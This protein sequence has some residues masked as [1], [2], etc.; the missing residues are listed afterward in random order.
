MPGAYP[1][2]SVEPYQGRIVLG[3]ELF[4]E[5]MGDPTL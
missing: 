1:E 3:P 2:P 4:A 5:V